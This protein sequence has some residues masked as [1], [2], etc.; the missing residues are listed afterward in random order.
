MTFCSGRVP[1]YVHPSLNWSLKFRFP[2][3]IGGLSRDDCVTTELDTGF[4]QLAIGILSTKD[5]ETVVDTE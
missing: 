2:L 3:D 1:I 5:F 4:L